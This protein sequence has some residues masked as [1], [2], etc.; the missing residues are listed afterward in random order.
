MRVGIDLLSLVPGNVGGAEIYARMVLREL[1]GLDPTI[2]FALFTNVENRGTFDVGD[3]A[4]TH[5]VDCPVRA[6]RRPLRLAYD[7]V[8]LPRQARRQHIDVLFAPNYT[9]PTSRHFA[10]VAAILDLRHIDLPETFARVHHEVHSR[11]VAHAVRSSAQVITLSEHAKRRIVAVYGI[12]PERVTVTHLA[13]SAVYSAHVPS[14]EIQRVRQKYGLS[15]P[16][17]LSVASLFPHKN[18]PVLIEALTALREMDVPTVQ[19]ALVGL[20]ATP[21]HKNDADAL[22]ARIGAAHLNERVV[23]TGWVPDADLPALYQGAMAFV[24]P[25]RYEGFGLPVLEAMASGTPVITTTAASL[26]EVAG[27][28]ALLVDPDDQAALVGALRRV[29]EDETLRTDLAARGI[30]R[31]REFT[32]RKTAEATLAAFRRADPRAPKTT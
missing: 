10:S 27:G 3:G 4:N 17:L 28:A 21:I 13:P 15:Q 16:Y 31:A 14:D 9:T 24:L 2:T 12:S 18:L 6:M 29:I 25:S 5:E 20:D 11:V 7:Y 1:P 26:P 32:W 8:I 22:R 23:M 30:D 19:L